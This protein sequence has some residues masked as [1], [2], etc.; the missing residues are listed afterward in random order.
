M[1][2]LRSPQLRN[3][4]TFAEAVRNVAELYG[5]VVVP[6][7]LLLL[8]FGAWM[9]TDFFG[10]WNFRSFLWLAG[11]VL[12]IVFEF[13]ERNTV[14]RLYLLRLRRIATNAL[15]KGRITRNSSW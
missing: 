5:G 14:T 15:E 13:V 11:M 1:S 4:R 8:V 7:V 6:S 10:V 12:L 3:L 2:D 9:I